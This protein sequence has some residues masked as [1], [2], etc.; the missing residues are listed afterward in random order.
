MSDVTKIEVQ[1]LDC[2]PKCAHVSE[3]VVQELR[4]AANCSLDSNVAVQKLCAIGAVVEK[5]VELVDILHGHLEALPTEQHVLQIL[6]NVFIRPL[7]EAIQLIDV[8]EQ[9]VG[10]ISYGFF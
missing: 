5:A 3:V 6:F 1:F 7:Q 4:H 2:V 9:D 8:L 10:N